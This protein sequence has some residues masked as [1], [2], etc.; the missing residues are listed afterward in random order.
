MRARPNEIFIADDDAGVRDAVYFAARH[1]GWIARTFADGPTLLAAT[2]TQSPACILL[3]V[4]MPGMTGL[5]VLKEL[6]RQ[7]YNRPVIMI[8]G[9][10]DVPMAVEAIRNGAADFIQKPFKVSDILL[11]L[12]PAME[13]A[14]LPADCA[15]PAPPQRFPGSERLTPRE[16]EVLAEV[17][18]GASAK[19]AGRA[20]GISPRTVEVHRSNILHKLGVKNAL[21]LMRVVLGWPRSAYAAHRLS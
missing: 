21:E 17:V 18:K 13:D 4:N 14:P 7:R 12:A 20:L 15:V 8:S 2:T 1:S 16:I 11:R 3:D 5:D 10:G 6:R 19:E 9:V